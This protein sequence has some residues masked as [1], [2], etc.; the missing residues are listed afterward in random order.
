M[1]KDFGYSIKFCERVP[2]GFWRER[3]YRIAEF[4]ALCWCSRDP[5]R[6]WKEFNEKYDERLSSEIRLI[7]DRDQYE[8]FDDGNC[9]VLCTANI[10]GGDGYGIDTLKE[11]MKKRFP[12]ID[13][14]CH[15]IMASDDPDYYEII[16]VK[17]GKEH[18][19]S[20]CSLYLIDYLEEYA[21]EE[22][23]N[24]INEAVKAELSPSD[25]EAIEKENSWLEPTE[26]WKYYLC[27]YHFGPLIEKIKQELLSTKKDFD[28]TA[29]EENPYQIP[30]CVLIEQYRDGFF[31]QI[32]EWFAL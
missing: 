15:M 19:N 8:C 1:S 32:P 29:T 9:F 16:I 26:Y 31:P 11:G 25:Y 22:L 14:E 10:E 17:D 3:K 7:D 18:Y 24:K 27:E 20:F 4:V 28:M 23:L 2:S 12:D 6:E 30:K 5:D 13:Y 21:S